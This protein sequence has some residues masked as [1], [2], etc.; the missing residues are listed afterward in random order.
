MFKILSDS[1]VRFGMVN[2]FQL[3]MLRVF[4]C[5]KGVVD[6]IRDN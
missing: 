5:L 6:S 3:V 2:L 4:D 1:G